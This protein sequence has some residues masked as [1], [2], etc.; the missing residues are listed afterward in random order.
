VRHDGKSETE[1]GGPIVY[2]LEQVLK[3]YGL[4]PDARVYI[5][6]AFKKCNPRIHFF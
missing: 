4:A 6:S 1:P 5:I 3:P 2:I